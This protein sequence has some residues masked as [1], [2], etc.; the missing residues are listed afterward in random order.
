MHRSS[1]EQCNVTIETMLPSLAGLDLTSRES[2]PTSEFFELKEKDQKRLQEFDQSD[3]FTQETPNI[4]DVNVFR[5]PKIPGVR[6]L[7][8]PRNV[9]DYK[10]YDGTQLWQWAQQNYLDPN[11]NKWSIDDWMALRQ[12][13]SPQ[14]EIPA[15]MHVALI[16]EGTDMTHDGAV[17]NRISLRALTAFA[18]AHGDDKIKQEENRVA[19]A[20]WGGISPLVNLLWSPDRPG[21]NNALNAA[22]VLGMLATVEENANAIA[23]EGGISPLLQLAT[24]RHFRRHA[25]TRTTKMRVSRRTSH[26]IDEAIHT[27]AVLAENST[28]A[29]NSIVSNEGIPLLVDKIRNFVEVDGI[30]NSALA[31]GNLARE[32]KFADMIADAG[33]IELLV[34]LVRDGDDEEQLNAARALRNFANG[35]RNM[36]LVEE[37]DGFKVL[38]HA[39][40]KHPQGHPLSKACKTSL[41]YL[42][43]VGTFSQTFER[44]GGIDVLVDWL[45]NGKSPKQKA[46]AINTLANAQD[47][48]NN[49]DVVLTEE[50]ISLVVEFCS[51]TP[52]AVAENATFVLKH[53]GNKRRQLLSVEMLLRVD[54]ETGYVDCEH[55]DNT[56]PKFTD[57]REAIQNYGNI[58]DFLKAKE[59]VFDSECKTSDPSTKTLSRMLQNFKILGAAATASN[60]P[61][62]LAA[63][64][65][66]KLLV[67]EVENSKKS[68]AWINK[69]RESWGKA[70]T[71]LRYSKLI[72]A[73]NEAVLA[74]VTA[75]AGILTTVAEAA[76]TKRAYSLVASLYG[77]EASVADTLNR[78]VTAAIEWARG[79]EERMDTPQFRAMEEINDNYNDDALRAD[80]KGLGLEESQ[81]QQ[82]MRFKHLLAIAGSIARVFN[83]EAAGP[84]VELADKNGKVVVLADAFV[85]LLIEPRR[86]DG[87]HFLMQ[88]STRI[89]G[90]HKRNFFDILDTEQKMEENQTQPANG[91]RVQQ[92]RE[93]ASIAASLADFFGHENVARLHLSAKDLHPLLVAR[94]G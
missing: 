50:L 71:L 61:S 33:G 83:V 75:G 39:R 41:R 32:D 27:L 8:N 38:R 69:S 6:A 93:A 40:D 80:L 15:F 43:K 42:G 5:I 60:R 67:V 17:R 19:I 48:R 85:A 76:V 3:I 65:L 56:F 16:R 1:S 94:H 18:D 29:R 30:A 37:A 53:L 11:R 23:E 66:L 68:K 26:Q 70:M 49:D 82:A 34:G 91:R 64:T 45:R 78:R 28:V 13:Y 84:D 77:D 54:A 47:V 12:R 88:P 36:W 57:V 87:T 52:P 59:R 81:I 89:Y 92:R 20:E 21:E 10:W 51:G 79:K 90:T 14:F 22:R 86:A 73:S 55:W 35:F 62:H 24:F 4:N 58:Y 46:M 72:A 9:E 74:A 63:K 44:A 2:A 7:D 25:I 31:L